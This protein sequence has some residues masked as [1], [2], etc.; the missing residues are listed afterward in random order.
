MSP[1]GAPLHVT[2]AVRCGEI[3][4]ELGLPHMVCG[5]VASSLHGEPRSTNDIDFVV[6]F[7]PS[8]VATLVVALEPEF[9]VDR[10]ALE[11]AA[12]TNSSCNVIHR[13]SAIK[14][15]IFAVRDRPFSWTE[16]ARAATSEVASG[17]GRL[18][19]TSAEDMVL[20][21]LEWYRKGDEVSDRQWR[22]VLGLLKLQDGRLDDAY[23]DKWAVE[24]GVLDLLQRAR[25]EGEP[26]SE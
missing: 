26:S 25:L 13:D 2:V 1:E 22:D 6:D 8:D 9:F 12:G 5:S 20:T 19:F 11:H 15:D 24:L 17:T 16:L 4:K 18:R 3:F 23:L 21:K 10:N 7:A 14:V